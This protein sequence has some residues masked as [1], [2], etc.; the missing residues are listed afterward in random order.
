MTEEPCLDLES[1][2]RRAEHK[3]SHAALRAFLAHAHAAQAH[4]HAGSDLCI[5]L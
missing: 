3:V 4:H 2:A 1:A 5:R